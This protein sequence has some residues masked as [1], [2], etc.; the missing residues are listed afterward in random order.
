MAGRVKAS[1]C[2]P[3]NKLGESNCLVKIV[4]ICVKISMFG[5]R[6]NS[7]RIQLFSKGVFFGLI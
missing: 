4:S 5:N 3:L 7:P 6:P 1:T 2:F